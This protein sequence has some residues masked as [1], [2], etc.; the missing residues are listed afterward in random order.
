MDESILIETVHNNIKSLKKDLKFWQNS[1]HKDS[2]TLKIIQDLEQDLKGE[3]F[4]L[5]EAQ[6]RIERSFY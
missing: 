5:N 4:K 2:K 6:K 3:Q 1:G